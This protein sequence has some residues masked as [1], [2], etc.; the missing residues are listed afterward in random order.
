MNED[1][2][3]T[4]NE[5]IENID[6][7]ENIERIENV[8]NAQQMTIEEDINN[9]KSLGVQFENFV[10]SPEGEE[11][12]AVEVIN[13]VTEAVES[14]KNSEMEVIPTKDEIRSKKIRNV[15]MDTV[16]DM[17]RDKSHQNS[18][19]KST[20]VDY[21]TE[22]KSG[23]TKVQL[24]TNHKTVFTRLYPGG[25]GAKKTSDKK[26]P[27]TA[28]SSSIDK[29][30]LMSTDPKINE[31]IERFKNYQIAKNNK[32][33]DLRRKFQEEENKKLHKGNEY[34]KTPT[35]H[36]HKE[37][38]DFLTR[39]EKYTKLSNTKKKQRI[40][41]EESKKL[42]EEEKLIEEINKKYKKNLDKTYLVEKINGLYEWE[43]NRIK[44]I[45]TIKQ[46]EIDKN[47]KE[48]TFKPDIDKSSQKISTNKNKLACSENTIERLY[49]QDIIKR[50]HK[51]EI[52]EDIYSPSFAPII[53]TNTTKIYK[54]LNTEMNPNY[55]L[56][57]KSCTKPTEC[58]I[59]SE[60]ITNTKDKKDDILTER[61]KLIRSKNIEN[62]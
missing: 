27:T 60:Y 7:I 44:K 23:K 39:M 24:G 40:E 15:S 28:K 12:S 3:V 19:G 1:E 58:N 14:K 42:K 55:L 9:L 29:D 8:E 26:K 17:D 2:N 32:F 52:L 48:C 53:N 4:K 25:A 6:H 46:S 35:K 37:G 41:D 20:S 57:E 51:K 5:N 47:F 43:Q 34:D 38:D 22:R 30:A 21:A 31:M 18:K 16:R 11:I 10:K 62:I 36:Q 45:N 49:K 56:T 54:N 13:E 61:V 33:A 50:K 59:E